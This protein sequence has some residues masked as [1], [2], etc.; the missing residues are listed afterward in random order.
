[1]NWKTEAIE[2]LRQYEAKK[3][4]LQNIPREIKR[5]ESVMR[6]I[7][8]AAADGTPVSGG[9]SGREDMMLSNIVHREEL[10]RSMEQAR[11]WVNQVDAGLEILS[12][13]ERL[14]LERFY[15][16][17]EKGAADRLAGDLNLDVKT[18]YKRKDAALRHFTVSLYGAVDN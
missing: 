13:E 17:P 4:S 15:I 10:N 18:V 3:Q 11:T 8:S 9:G 1:M 5:L 2:K 12:Q 7:R 16:K 14:I 6:G